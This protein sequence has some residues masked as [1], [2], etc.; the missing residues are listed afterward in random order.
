MT[1]TYSI[2]SHT[3]SSFDILAWFDPVDKD[4]PGNWEVVAHTD[5]WFHARDLLGDLTSLDS[6]DN[7]R[8]TPPRKVLCPQCGSAAFFVPDLAVSRCFACGY[9]LQ[10]SGSIGGSLESV[11]VEGETVVAQQSGLDPADDPDMPPMIKLFKPETI[12]YEL[13]AQDIESECRRLRASGAIS[14]LAEWRI[15]QLLNLLPTSEK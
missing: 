5:R 1:R 11:E 14:S 10:Q 15:T 7:E 9:P 2:L 12:S 6:V 13:L 4:Q 3:A 8:P